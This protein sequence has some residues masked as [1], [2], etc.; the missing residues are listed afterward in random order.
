MMQIA[1]LSVWDKTGL[2]PFATR[3]TAAIAGYLSDLIGAAQPKRLALYPATHLSY[4]ENPHQ[5]A[6][7]Y[8]LQPEGS[9]LGGR[10]LQGKGLSYHNMLDLATAW[11][12]AQLHEGPAAVVVKHTSPC[13]L[14]VAPSPAEALRWAIRCDP[15]S[16]FGS[17]IATNR[18][19]DQGCVQAIVQPG[20]SRHDDQA[21][22]AAD[23]AGMAMVFTSVRHFRH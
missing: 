12:A 5:Q 3:L 8:N 18:E 4:G 2:I 6:S 15:V 20:G 17:V 22:A 21:N 11:K 7:F 19:F 13:G 23:K 1:L 10:L 16:A 9:P 14:A